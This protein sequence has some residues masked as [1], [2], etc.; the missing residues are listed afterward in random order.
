MSQQVSS[1]TEGAFDITVAPLVNVWGFGFKHSSSV[2]KN[3]IDSIRSI[4]GY[5]KFLLKMVLLISR[6]H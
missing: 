5:E 6:T 2:S 4:V 3:K 1:A